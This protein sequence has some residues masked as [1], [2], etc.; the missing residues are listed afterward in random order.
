MVSQV[1]AVTMTT[2]IMSPA[3]ADYHTLS[4]AGNRVPD[5]RSQVSGPRS[6]VSVGSQV[7][8]GV[9]LNLVIQLHGSKAR[10]LTPETR[11]LIADS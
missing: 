9:R 1:D 8:V 5:V 2:I 4:G 10:Y 6:W 7:L 11:Q 3:D